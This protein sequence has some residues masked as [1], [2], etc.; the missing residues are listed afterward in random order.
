MT[1]VDRPW[2]RRPLPLAVISALSSS[3]LWLMSLGLS[4]GIEDFTCSAAASAAVPPP[5]QF[6][7]VLLVALNGVLLL[8]TL[9][10]GVIG[11]LVARSAHQTDGPGAARF[12]GYT[13][14]MLAVMYAYSIV[15][16]G[17]HPLIM[18]AC[19]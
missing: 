14:A 3:V 15:L 1:S 6:L 16:I 7:Q 9:A 5:H 4:Y 11:F 10:A 19:S 12:F 8:L 18:E 13:G 2:W 17:V